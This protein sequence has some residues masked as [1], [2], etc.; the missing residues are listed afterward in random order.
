MK[1]VVILTSPAPKLT[2]RSQR[3]GEE[4][5]TSYSRCR[6]R[7]ATNLLGNTGS[8]FVPRAGDVAEPSFTFISA[9][10]ED[11]PYFQNKSKSSTQKGHSSIEKG[12]E[13]ST[14]KITPSKGSLQT[15]WLKFTEAIPGF[16]L[17]QH[18]C[19]LH[20]E[21]TYPQGSKNKF[22]SSTKRDTVALNKVKKSAQQKS[23]LQK[24]FCSEHANAK[25]TETIPGFILSQHV[26][27]LHE[28]ELILRV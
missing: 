14:T 12:Q 17:S 7:D 18:V 23:P 28:E 21:T 9:P 15:T 11:A 8:V 2:R 16:I 19:Q 10:C 24:A 6:V 26:C 27:Q 4:A 3:H 1:V 22:K 13:I 25:C 20:E 5:T